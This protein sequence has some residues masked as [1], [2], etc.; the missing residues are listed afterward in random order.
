MKAVR[1][2]VRGSGPFPLDMLR[3]AEAWP[4]TDFDAG[5]IGRSLAESA[6][7]RDDDRW[8]VTLRGRRFCEKR[9]NSFMCEVRE[10]A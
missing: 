1:Y 3:Y 2:Q 10:V 6:A 8:V 9:W 7:A 5:T 4:D